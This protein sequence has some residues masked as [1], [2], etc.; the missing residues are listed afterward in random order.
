MNRADEDGVLLATRSHSLVQPIKTILKTSATG[1]I[2]LRT[3]QQTSTHICPENR[4]QGA[5]LLN[6]VARGEV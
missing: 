2:R 5:V 4:R 6:R 3:V 1:K